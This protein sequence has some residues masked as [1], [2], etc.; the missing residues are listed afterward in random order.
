LKTCMEKPLGPVKTKSLF[1][2][3]EDPCRGMPYPILR[4]DF[5]LEFHAMAISY[6]VYDFLSKIYG[7]EK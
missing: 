1:R 2:F 7:T 6:E 5:T 4:K 3:E